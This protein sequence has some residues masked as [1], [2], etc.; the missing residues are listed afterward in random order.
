MFS[1]LSSAQ[2]TPDLQKISREITPLQTAL[3]DDIRLNPTLFAR[4]KTVWENRD[5]GTLTPEQ[6][7]L[8]DD[9]YKGYVRA[10]ANLNAQQKER[11]RAINSEMALLSLKF[12]D[13]L[14]HDTSAYKL[15]IDRQDDLAGLS[16]SV[17]A[18]AADAARANGQ[19]GKWVFTLDA[20]SIWPFV[21]RLGA[22][23]AARADD[24]G[25]HDP[26]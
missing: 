14:L 25:V 23:R 18:A 9:T 20:P 16:P 8:V 7:K 26:G 17:V 21:Q 11:L 15:V 19:P 13:N 5:K 24:P 10:G 6:K 1:N 12:G 4:I 3:R 2:S 22:A